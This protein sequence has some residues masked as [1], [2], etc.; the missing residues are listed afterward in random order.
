M[1]F[2]SVRH[3]GDRLCRLRWKVAAAESLTGGRLQSLLTS[4][5]GASDY[6][7]GGVT[8]YTI[9]AKIQLLNVERQVAQPVNGVSA[10]VAAQMATGA[11]RLFATQIAVATTGYAEPYLEDDVATPV[12]YIAVC[13][14]AIQRVECIRPA[15]SRNEVQQAVAVAAIKLLQEVLE[16][17]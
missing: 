1:G 7:A 3:V 9:E 14:D 13:C 16:T 5:S 10:E 11:R 6:F 17:A 15:G 2:D 8:A 4:P 12:G